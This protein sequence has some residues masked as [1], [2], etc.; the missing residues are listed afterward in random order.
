MSLVEPSFVSITQV[1]YDQIR[2]RSRGPGC[3]GGA[4]VGFAVLDR[5]GA[6]FWACRMCPATKDFGGA[7]WTWC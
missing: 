7:G 5:D 3:A 6:K 1:A 2:R 4:H